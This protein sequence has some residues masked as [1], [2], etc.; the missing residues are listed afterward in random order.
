MTEGFEKNSGGTVL[1]R[2]TYTYDAVGN[3]T[4]IEDKNG[5]R[6]TYA[7]DAKSRLTQDA[8]TGLNTHTYDYSYDSRDNRLT[9]SET[10]SVSTFSYNAFG[11]LTTSVHKVFLPEITTYTYDLDGNLTVVA[12][13]TTDLVTMAYDDENRMVTHK[14]GATIVTYT[15]A[16]DGLK[17]TEEDDSGVTTILWDGSEY[18]QQRT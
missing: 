8:T 11:Q 10:G 15:Y 16:G 9:S 5:A 4:V 12:D 14:D 3:R 1:Q 6:T 7:Y 13:Q 17:R 18:L 2:F